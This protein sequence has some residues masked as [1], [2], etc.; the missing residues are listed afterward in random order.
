MRVSFRIDVVGA[1][2]R[3]QQGRPTMQI[4]DLQCLWTLLE[5]NPGVF[6]EEKP[7]ASLTGDALQD[8]G[9]TFQTGP[10]G[11]LDALTAVTFLRLTDRGHRRLAALG[12]SGGFLHGLQ[13]GPAPAEADGRSAREGLP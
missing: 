13:E 1:S 10:Y 3:L 11:P 12:C 7:V 4:Q 9:W 6:D 2:K 8:G 5:G